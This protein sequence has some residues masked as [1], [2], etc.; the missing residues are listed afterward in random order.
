MRVFAAVTA[1]LLFAVALHADERTQNLVDRLAREADAFERNAPQL[2]GR[3][4]FH[5][6]TL[7]PAPRPKIR[8]GKAADQAPEAIWQEREIVSQYGFALLD[9]AVH[10]LRQV[11]FVDGKRVT[12]ERRAQDELA[13]LIAASA[14]QR[15]RRSLQQFEKYG[16]RGS[17]TDFG[18]ILLLFSRANIERYEITYLGPRMLSPTRMQAFH[19]KQLDGPQALA[20][21]R[22]DQRGPMR[23]SGV[24]RHLSVEGEIWVRESDGL[25]LHVTLNATDG[26][27]D[28]ALREEAVVDYAVSE[29]GTVLPSQTIHR[30]LRDG[31]LVTENKFTYGAFH[32]FGAPR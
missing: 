9:Q 6:R 17:V 4:T 22:Q 13:K 30:E 26:S 11:T 31:M 28:Q 1:V 27:S 18:Q 14:D 32:K 25:P 5:Q 10:E 29:F 2:V 15:K 8:I 16:L 19:Y 23:H 20:V 7:A 21:Y 12:D 24:V 3:E